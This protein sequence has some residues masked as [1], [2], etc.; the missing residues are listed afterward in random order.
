MT[1]TLARPA[2]SHPE[3]FVLERTVSARRRFA[4]KAASVLMT[5]SLLVAAIPLAWV[6]YVVVSKGASGVQVPRLMCQTSFKV[7]TFDVVIWLSDE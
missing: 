6:L 3:P 1:A 5:L 4:N 7:L 2:P